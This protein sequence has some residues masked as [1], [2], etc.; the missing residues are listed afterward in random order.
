MLVDLANYDHA[1]QRSACFLYTKAQY[2]KDNLWGIC[3]MLKL[4]DHSHFMRQHKEE[5]PVRTRDLVLMDEPQP[6]RA[7]LDR[8]ESGMALAFARLDT[9][10]WRISRLKT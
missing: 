7:Y 8:R 1:P 5:S 9:D 3:K 4:C 2:V 10:L 6:L